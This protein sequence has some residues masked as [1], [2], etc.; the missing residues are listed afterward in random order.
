MAGPDTPLPR[1][2]L[3]GELLPSLVGI[4]SIYL[5]GEDQLRL[6]IF[7]AGAAVRVQLS[8]RLLTTSGEVVAF[9]HDVLPATDRSA[10]TLTRAI[11]EGWLLEATARTIAGTP[12]IGQCFAVL[13]IVR[14]STGNFVDLS[15]LAAGYVTV[16]NRLAWPGTGVQSSLDGAGALRSILGATPGAGGNVLETVPTG[17]RWE[18]LSLQFT[19]TTA[20]AAANRRVILILDDGVNNYAFVTANFTQAASLAFTYMWA[21]ALNSVQDANLST[22]MAP[23]PNNLRL[24]SGHRI[25]SSTQAIQGADQFSVVTY[26]V[27]EWIEGA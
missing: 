17:A 14:G 10:S 13:S 27:R 20:V 26:L 25:R 3:G 2:A 16:A 15:T 12:L 4:S 18:L 19:F 11:G 24:G 23:L 7:N 22:I 6:T 1:G 21:Q 9:A 8:G 5:T